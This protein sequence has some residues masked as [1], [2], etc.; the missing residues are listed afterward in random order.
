MCLILTI[1]FT[2]LGLR[3]IKRYLFH[4]QIRF[5]ILHVTSQFVSLK[6]GVSLSLG[7]YNSRGISVLSNQ[8]RKPSPTLLLIKPSSNVYILMTGITI[9]FLNLDRCCSCSQNKRGKN[10]HYAYIGFKICIQIQH[11]A[12]LQSLLT[13]MDVLWAKYDTAQLVKQKVKMYVCIIKVRIEP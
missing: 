10:T 9:H 7:A 8:H 4:L 3:E 2:T 6:K 12:K 13:D 5:S 1:L 11:W